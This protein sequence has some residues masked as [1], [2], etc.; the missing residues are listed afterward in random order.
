MSERSLAKIIW[1]F[2][3]CSGLQMLNEST[4]MFK[5]FYNLTEFYMM[6]IVFRSFCII[7]VSAFVSA[8]FSR[9]AV[10]IH[11]AQYRNMRILSQEDIQ[12]KLTY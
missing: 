9:L 5:I 3:H 6:T 10:T 11:P 2:S 12:V 7:S 8:I 1:V 4:Y